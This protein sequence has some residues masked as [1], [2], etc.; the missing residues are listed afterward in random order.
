VH[1]A[2]AEAD[3]A[4]GAHAAVRCWHEA[5]QVLACCVAEFFELLLIPADRTHRLV[6]AFSNGC[7]V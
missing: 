5:V 1:L 7:D 4:A 2:V 6:L 3:M